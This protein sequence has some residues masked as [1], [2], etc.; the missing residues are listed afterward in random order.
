M[1]FDPKTNIVT[2]AIGEKAK[3]E[4][5]LLKKTVFQTLEIDKKNWITLDKP[6]SYGIIEPPITALL[7]FDL[8]H[9]SDMQLSRIVKTNLI[10]LI[11]DH[12]THCIYLDSDTR[13]LSS[14][15]FRIFDILSDGYDLV[16]CPSTSQDYW[17]IDAEEKDFS[18][19]KLL[20]QPLQLQGGMFGFTVNDKIRDFFKH[21]S[22]GY[23]L[24]YNQDQLALI[25]A[26]HEC[27]IKYWL[28]GYPFNSDKGSVMK[29]MFG[30]TR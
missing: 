29:H 11:P 4:N 27:D 20:Y 3:K 23:M 16:I 21:F 10:N 2:I 25:R 7:S 1:A 13:I 22:N 5:E 8:Q 9:Y 6:K 17:H 15:F 24:Y 30:N 12:W 14:D 19:N 28:L 18:F 26:L